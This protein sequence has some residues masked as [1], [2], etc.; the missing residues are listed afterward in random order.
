MSA[1]AYKR[2]AAEAALKHIKPGMTVGLGTGSTAAHFIELLGKSGLDVT[3]VATSAQTE[4]LAR[5]AGLKLTTLDEMPDLDITV[6]GADE[7]DPNVRLIK[8]GGGALLREKIVAGASK[9]VIIIADESKMVK[10]LGAFPLPVEVTQ[11]GSESV[12]IIMEEL[13]GAA[14]AAGQ[15]EFRKGPDG[16]RVVTENGNF[17][18]DCDLE[19]IEEPE[20]L[21]AIFKQIAG[22]IEVGLF[23]GIASRAIIAGPKGVREIEAPEFDPDDFA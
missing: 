21:E 2:K 5:K 8:G 19:E 11:F 17:I 1:D 10:I 20:M 4:A 23:C 14:G 18:I 13:A 12:R 15:M 7:I 16:K 6:D 9:E 3:C 22:V